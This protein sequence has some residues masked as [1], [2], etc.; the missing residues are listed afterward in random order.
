M[1]QKKDKLERVLRRQLDLSATPKLSEAS[2][3]RILGE[4]L[5][6]GPSGEMPNVL[7][8]PSTSPKGSQGRWWQ[9]LWRGSIRVP[10]PVAFAILALVG[11][12][13]GVVLRGGRSETPTRAQGSSH[14]FNLADF[15]PVTDAN[16]R[17]LGGSDAR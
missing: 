12:L 9:F 4:L 15:Q 8:D 6:I 13:T 5:R 7:S 1:N 10:V 2:R 14:E 17:V 11:L 3:E 16:V